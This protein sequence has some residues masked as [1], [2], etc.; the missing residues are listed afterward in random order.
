MSWWGFLLLFLLLLLVIGIVLYINSDQPAPG[1]PP[2]RCSPDQVLEAYV[3]DE[4]RPAGCPEWRNNLIVTNGRLFEKDF[5]VEDRCCVY[6]NKESE[7]KPINN[8]YICVG[9]EGKILTDEELNE[10]PYAFNN[11]RTIY[12]TP[13]CQ[14]S[15]GTFLKNCIALIQFGVDKDGNALYKAYIYAGSGSNTSIPSDLSRTVFTIANQCSSLL[16]VDLAGVQVVGIVDGEP[17]FLINSSTLPDLVVEV[18]KF[19]LTRGF[20][21]IAAANPILAEAVA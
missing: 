15:G 3:R 12:L 6:S 13:Q 21:P 10:K 7:R 5:V 1:P 16:R 19:F 20:Q 9:L 8:P 18:T 17:A 11:N 2:V 4:P 14:T